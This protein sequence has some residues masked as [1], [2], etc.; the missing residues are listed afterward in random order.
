MP[1]LMDLPPVATELGA[2][3]EKA[4]HQLFL[5][6]GAIR[7][8][9]RGRTGTELDFSTDARPEE[10]IRILRGWADTKK[11]IGIR[12]GTVGARKDEYQLEITTFRE[13]AYA[14]D[15]RQPVVTFAKDVETDLSRRD[16]TINAMAIALLDGE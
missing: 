8:A 11:L 14:E 2:R 3:F 9:V 13:E 4:G 6:G 16:F 1:D 15:S 5:V 12:F 7:D 10:V